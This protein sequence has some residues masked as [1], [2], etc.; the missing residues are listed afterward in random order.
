[1]SAM[2]QGLGGN[3]RAMIV[4][5]MVIWAVLGVGGVGYGQDAA[6][7][8]GAELLR[9]AEGV[10]APDSKGASGESAGPYH[11]KA[12]FQTWDFFGKADGVGTV[13][14][15]ADG[16]GR[17]RREVTYR[18]K[19]E[20][21]VESKGRY[22]SVEEFHG[23]ISERALVSAF[24]DP[25][26]EGDLQRY[27]VEVQQVTQNGVGMDCVVVHTPAVDPVLRAGRAVARDTVYCL[28]GPAKTLRVT[29]MKNGQA[30]LYNR[31]EP[32]GEK[33]FARDLTLMQGKLRRGVMQVET[34]S[35][36]VV[37]EAR[38]AVPAGAERQG[39]AGSNGG[40]ARVA[41]G[42]QAGSKIS[43]S[44][45]EYPRVARMGRVEGQ[46]VISAVVSKTGVLED[47]EVVSAPDEA[48]A[49]ASL[50]ALKDWRYKPYLLGGKPM[51]VQTTITQN[52]YLGTRQ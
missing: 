22:V 3:G 32:M 47:M 14:E 21:T 26:P 35:A 18:G 46:V 11:F 38:L 39:G 8:Q 29:Q 23:S 34:M 2:E 4:R 9:K 1:M 41:G 37:E 40:G 31:L 50:E 20:T 45:P 33:I 36:W 17:W 30:M 16:A 43:G 49:R 51:S 19:T 52:F 44:E 5:A 15:F 28:A 24:F 25:L 6:A 42:V 7:A 10:G 27:G 13:E 48:L 12:G